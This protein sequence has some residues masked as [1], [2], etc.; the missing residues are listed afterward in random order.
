MQ[1]KLGCEVEI[2]WDFQLI[3][4]YNGI[5]ERHLAVVEKPF[6]KPMVL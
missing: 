3:P 6:L 1:V 4:F 2:V 5:R